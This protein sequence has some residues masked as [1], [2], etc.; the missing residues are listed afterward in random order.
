MILLASYLVVGRLVWLQLG[1][2]E[3]VS[4]L[5]AG[6][7]M[8]WLVFTALAET[9][10][11]TAFGLGGLL[12][13]GCGVLVPMVVPTSF[14]PLFSLL[15]QAHENSIGYGALSLLCAFAGA[16]TAVAGRLSGFGLAE[17]RHDDVWRF[18]PEGRLAT[19]KEKS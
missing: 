11:L 5:A 7:V 13:A 12:G 14:D 4:Y 1:P 6:G 3:F 16:F 8:A 15:T 2:M 17:S 18:N 19:G 9:P 10:L